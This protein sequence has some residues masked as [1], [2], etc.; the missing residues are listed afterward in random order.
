[1]ANLVVDYGHVT[2]ERHRCYDIRRRCHAQDKPSGVARIENYLENY[3]A[4]TIHRVSKIVE[5][6]VDWFADPVVLFETLAGIREDIEYGRYMNRRL[7][8]LPFYEFE[9]QVTYKVHRHG[10]PVIHVGSRHNYVSPSTGTATGQRQVT[11]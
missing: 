4:W 6:Y 11:R 8:T 9:Q 10:T 5:Y 3:T 1:M 2:H 7:H